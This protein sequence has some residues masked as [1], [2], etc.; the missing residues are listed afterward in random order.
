MKKYKI[1][2]SLLEGGS[3]HSSSRLVDPQ[4]YCL[5]CHKSRRVGHIFPFATADDGLTVNASPQASTSEDLRVK[6]DQPL[7]HEDYKI[8]LVQSL[9]DAARVF[10]LAF[11]GQSSG[12][13]LSW[14]SFFWLG[15]DQNA[16]LQPLS[17][18]MKFQ[19][20]LISMHEF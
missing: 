12:S 17:Y 8:T 5:T 15:V 20:F 14:F 18:Q 4:L 2:R 9:R 3:V 1:K 19:V 11:R 16:R 13:N 10:E 6:Q 7:K